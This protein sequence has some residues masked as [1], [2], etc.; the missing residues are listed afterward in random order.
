[1]RRS[2]V[3]VSIA[4]TLTLVLVWGRSVERENDGSLL[5]SVQARVAAVAPKIEGTWLLTVTAQRRSRRGVR[6][7]RS[8]DF[9]GLF[10]SKR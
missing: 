8:S 10:Y 2:S 5:P 9:R 1:M 6:S 7:A 4:A 3:V